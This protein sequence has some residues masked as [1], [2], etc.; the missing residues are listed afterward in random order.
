MRLKEKVALIT[1]GA[2]GIGRSSAVLFAREGAKV[3]IADQNEAGSN[4]VAG[5]IRDQGGE[6][7]VLVGDVTVAGVAKSM[8]R[9]AVDDYG[10]LDILVNSAGVTPRNAFSKRTPW[11]Q[12]WVRVIEVNLTG[13]YLVTRQAASAMTRSGGGSIIN[14]ASIMG[15][16]GYPPELSGGW[17]PYNPSK[18]GVI[19][20]TRNLAVEL[21]KNNI[22]VNCICPGFIF[23]P[24]T[25]ELSGDPKILEALTER[26]PLGRLG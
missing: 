24:M 19:L 8:V 20:F 23:T 6:A 25:E 5:E 17:T 10:R 2:S 15:L 9:T 21:A 14:L 11:D 7:S 22:R 4:E 12:I 13:T 1:G 16:V 18:G 3:V 26:H